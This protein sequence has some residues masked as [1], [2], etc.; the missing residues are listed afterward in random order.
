MD[1]KWKD[2]DVC[3][4][5]PR[6]GGESVVQVSEGWTTER[7]GGQRD[8]TC[9]RAGKQC[10]LSSSL[11]LSPSLPLSFSLSSFSLEEASPSTGDSPEVLVG[12]TAN[13][14][15]VL[16][17]NGAHAKHHGNAPGLLSALQKEVDMALEGAAHEREKGPK[18]VSGEENQRAEVVVVTRRR[19]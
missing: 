1:G 16:D 17:D 13:D 10:Q 9:D 5:R 8:E 14:L 19:L 2:V 11:A 4:R 15:A 18:G 3:R 7:R 12:P 6:R